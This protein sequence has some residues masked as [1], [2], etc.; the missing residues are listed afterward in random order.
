MEEAF[1]NEDNMDIDEMR[2]TPKPKKAI[3]WTIIIPIIAVIIIALIIVLIIFLIKSDDDN[4][5]HM[6]DN[7]SFKAE[8][9]TKSKN[10]IVT[11]IY[12]LYKDNI[13]EMEIDDKKISKINNVFTFKNP[14]NHTILMLLDI[15]NLTSLHLFNNSENLKSIYFSKQFNTENITSLESLF[16]YCF[17]LES[18]DISNFNTEKVES[19]ED[20]FYFCTSLKTIKFPNST[21]PNLKIMSYMFSGCESLTSVDLSYFNT[22][23]VE[24]MFFTFFGCV[25]LAS[26][27]LTKF[28]TKNLVNMAGLLANCNSLTSIDMF[29]FITDK[30]EYMFN[31]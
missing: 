26:I 16:S 14:G 5:K 29:N 10:E 23:N 2:E 31:L 25:S 22:E 3:R 15:D 27:D 9:E 4:E 6:G 17:S 28:N 11:L 12:D 20:M 30:V 13:I 1:N 8:Y 24:D 21:T 18:V 19:M 7:Y